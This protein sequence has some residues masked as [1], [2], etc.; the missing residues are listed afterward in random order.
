MF[1]D[2]ISD[3]NYEMFK[4]YSGPV[5]A[6]AVGKSLKDLIPIIKNVETVAS[7]RRLLEYLC[8]G[9][10]VAKG[11]GKGSVSEQ[12]TRKFMSGFAIAHFPEEYFMLTDQNQ[13]DNARLTALAKAMQA[14]FE[15][16]LAGFETRRPTDTG[17]FLAAAKEYM[18][19]LREWMPRDAVRVSARAHKMVI[20]HYMHGHTDAHEQVM[21]L[22][23]AIKVSA[24]QSALDEL[25]RH[26]ERLMES[27]RSLGVPVPLNGQVIAMGPG[28]R[29]A[30]V[31]KATM[32]SMDGRVL[33]EAEAREYVT[34]M[35]GA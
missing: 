11:F 25:D 13:P 26:K 31:V 18:A 2:L 30:V 34:V 7:T 6:V 27:M 19:F 20:L 12:A 32:R 28:G 10:D 15:A 35:P 3:K 16:V 5:S 33:S 17:V 23:E 8:I 14:A 21:I 1:H 4:N 29:L 24:G 22:R 9:A